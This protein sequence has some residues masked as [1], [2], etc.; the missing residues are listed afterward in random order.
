MMSTR[1]GPRINRFQIYSDGSESFLLECR[2]NKS[3]DYL[4]KSIVHSSRDERIKNESSSANCSNGKFKS[5]IRSEN[6]SLIRGKQEMVYEHIYL[7]GS[8]PTISSIP[9][10]V[11]FPDECLILPNPTHGARSHCQPEKK[12]VGA[13]LKDGRLRAKELGSS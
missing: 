4:L 5:S 11:Q 9:D 2:V 10:Q 6:K 12:M 8:M 1:T 7:A 13:G 3:G